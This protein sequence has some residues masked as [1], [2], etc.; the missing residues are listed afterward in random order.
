MLNELFSEGTRTILQADDANSMYFSIENRSPFLDKELTEFIYTVP[1]EYLM[2]NGFTK[3][4]L[5]SAMKGIVQ[6]EILDDKRKTGFNINVGSMFDLK[7]D[8]MK[9]NILNKRNK[10]FNIINRDRILALLNDKNNIKKYGKFIFSFIN[11]SIFLN[12]YAVK[13]WDL[14]KIIEDLDHQKYQK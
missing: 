13:K 2:K 1:T 10:I 12:K 6:K 8:Y 4:I 5:R 3:F 7:S 11:T 14:K 9:K